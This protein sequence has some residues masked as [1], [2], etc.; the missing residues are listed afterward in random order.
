LFLFLLL[1]LL[2]LLYDMYG[3]L[4]SCFSVVDMKS[5]CVLVISCC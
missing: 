4:N 1:L 5:G 2:L 3:W